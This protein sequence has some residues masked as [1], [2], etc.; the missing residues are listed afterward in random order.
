MW[1]YVGFIYL[2]YAVVHRGNQ[3]LTIRAEELV[4]GDVVD[5]KFGDRIPA[6]IRIVESRGFKVDNS[7]LTGESEPQSRSCDYTNANPLETRNLAFFS[8]NAVEGA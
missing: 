6:D 8:T 7:S 1:N 4:I 5:V 2:Q 3:T